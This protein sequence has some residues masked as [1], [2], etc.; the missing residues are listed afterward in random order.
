MQNKHKPHYTAANPGCLLACVRVGL[1]NINH[2]FLCGGTNRKTY[3]KMELKYFFCAL[4]NKIEKKEN[5]IYHDIILILF[6]YIFF[7]SAAVDKNCILHFTGNRHPLGQ[8]K[9]KGAAAW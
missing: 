4:I 2:R 9:G 6:V 7:S 8:S 3:I 1:I 5:K